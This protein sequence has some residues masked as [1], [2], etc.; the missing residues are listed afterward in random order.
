MTMTIQQLLDGIKVNWIHVNVI[1]QLS[2]TQYIVG[3]ATGLAIMETGSITNHEKHIELGKGLKLIKPSKIETDVIGWD[4]R[5]SPMKTKPMQL[6]K[7]DKKRMAKLQNT[8]KTNLSIP[9]PDFIDFQT[10]KN[11]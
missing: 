8:S 10:I 11:N 7:L 9:T 5:F 1:E 4:I 3:D 6:P 2:P